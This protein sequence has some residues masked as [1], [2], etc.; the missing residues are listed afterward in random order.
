MRTEAGKNKETQKVKAVKKDK[1]S[2]GRK[3]ENKQK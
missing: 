2:G 3:S 1:W